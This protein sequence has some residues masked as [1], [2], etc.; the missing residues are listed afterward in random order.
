LSSFSEVDANEYAGFVQDTIRVSDHFALSLG[1]R[2][3]A[4]P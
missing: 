3:D 1:A 4:P 2:Y